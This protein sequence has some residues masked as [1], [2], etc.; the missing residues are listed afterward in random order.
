MAGTVAHPY[1]PGYLEGG[2]QEIKVQGQPGK[3]VMKTPSQPISQT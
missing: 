2:D 3:K 1:N